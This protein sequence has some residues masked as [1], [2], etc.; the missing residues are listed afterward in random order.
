MMKGKRGV[1][2]AMSLIAISLT[3]CGEDYTYPDANWVD[4]EIVTVGG[5]TYK[6]DEIYKIFKEQNGKT[7]AQSYFN[8]AKSILAQAVTTRSQGLL[9]IV[10]NKMENLHDTWKTNARTNNTSYKEEQE[11]TFDSEG[12]ENEEE[13]RE[14]YISQQQISQNQTSFETVKTSANNSNEEYYLSEDLTKQYVENKAPYHVSHILIKVDAAS[15]GEGYYNGQISSDDAK[16]IYNVTRMLANGTSFG[17]VAQIASDDQSNTQYGE[18]YTKDNMVAMQKDTSYVNE[19]KLGVYAYD[20]FLNPKTKSGSTDTRNASNKTVAT[21]LRV[22]GTKDGYNSESEVADDIS[23]TLVGQGKAFGIPLSVCYE[24]NSV[25]DWESNPHDGSSIKTSNGKSISARQYPRNVLFNSFFNYHGVS[26]IYNDKGKEFEDRFL[27]EVNDIM[28][29]KAKGDTTTAVQFASIQDFKAAAST[30][31]LEYKADEY[32][33]IEAQL[34]N[35]DDS[36]FVE[37]DGELVNYNESLNGKKADI[38]LDNAINGKKV[39]SDGKGNPLIVA[40]AGTS[41]DSGYQGIHFISVNNDPFT[42]D[43]NGNVSNKYKYYRANVPDDSKKDGNVT[44]A[45]YSSDYDTNPSFINFVNADSNSTTTY[46]NRRSTVESVIKKSFDSEDITLWRY[47]LAEF[48]SKTNKDFMDYLAPEVKNE[49]NKYIIL[50]EKSSTDSANETLDSS[51]ETYIN[52]INIQTEYAEDRMV[53]L[54]GIA[55]FEAGEFTP[56]MEEACYVA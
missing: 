38:S 13:L 4:H 50:T 24:M 2:L 27:A 6:Y 22:P 25:A 42:G 45:A 19:F 18:L 9:S 55:Y 31:N 8:L 17:S 23:Q 16:Q 51:W 26:F 32:D 14:K 20:T 40:R 29:A 1:A 33:A 21:S 43:K 36:A 48:K 54:K 46:N 37:Y 53:P 3:A 30:Y 41:G 28:V 7:S 39:L 34:S 11:K 15:G 12:V 49:I 10:D 44:I 35:L 5:K 47:N 52:T 56:E